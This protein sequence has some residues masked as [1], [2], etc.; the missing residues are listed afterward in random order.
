ML[1]SLT[2]EILK[3][4]ICEGVEKN[5]RITSDYLKATLNHLNLGEKDFSDIVHLVNGSFWKDENKENPDIFIDDDMIKRILVIIR[6]PSYR[7]RLRF[8]K[9]PKKK[10]HPKGDNRFVPEMAET[11]K[12]GSALGLIKK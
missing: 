3:K 9:Y 6:E 7:S 2:P 1:V 5:G 12:I 10:I 8:V 4:I 11:D